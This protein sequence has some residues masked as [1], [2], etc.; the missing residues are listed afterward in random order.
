MEAFGKTLS[1]ESVKSLNSETQ[2]NSLA[3]VEGTLKAF[4]YTLSLHVFDSKT[5]LKAL[6]VRRARWRRS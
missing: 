3:K 6:Q 1:L 2:I 4:L 5:K